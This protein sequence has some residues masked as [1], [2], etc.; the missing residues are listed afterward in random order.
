MRNFKLF[1][2]LS[3]LLATNCA[4]TTT[5]SINLFN[6]T[7]T[8]NISSIGTAVSIAY[9]PM[10]HYLGIALTNAIHLYNLE[11]N[12]WVGTSIDTTALINL[13]FIYSVD[14]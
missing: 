7:K 1:F 5:S 9:N 13:D 11:T 4:T 10:N 3:L 2:I 6:C 14:Y 8:V 12:A